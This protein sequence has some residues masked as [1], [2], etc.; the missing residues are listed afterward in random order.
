MLLAEMVVFYFSFFAVH[1]ISYRNELSRNL[2]STFIYD[3]YI[4]L[5]PYI[6]E[7]EVKV[8]VQSKGRNRIA[9]GM[10]LKGPFFWLVWLQFHPLELS[11]QLKS[12]LSIGFRP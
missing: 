10:V 1:N 11:T 5:Q 2:C 7:K 3:D 6:N 9:E 4:T 8:K 12:S